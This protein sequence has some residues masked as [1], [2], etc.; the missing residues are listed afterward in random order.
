[1]VYSRDVKYISS[2]THADEAFVMRQ[3]VWVLITVS[4][5][6]INECTK[7]RTFIGI[8]CELTSREH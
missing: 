7:G 6:F 8:D 2:A 5:N 1:M 3:R 4:N